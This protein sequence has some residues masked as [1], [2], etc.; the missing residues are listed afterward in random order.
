[1]P[2]LQ[3]HLQLL[4]AMLAGWV[5]EQQL[6]VI[7]YLKEEN[8]VLRG[9]LGPKRP[10]F[11]D[12]QRRRLAVKGKQLGRR[13]LAEIGCIVTPDTILRWHRQLI[14][15][16]YDGI[17]RRR[18][19]RPRVM[20]EMRQLVVQMARDNE[21][22]G[23]MRI[24]GALANLGHCVSRSTVRRILAEHGIDPAPER[25]RHTPWNKFLKA[26]WRMIA[27]ADFF[28]VEIWTRAGLTRY[29]VLFVID[30][31]S[32]RVN[33]AGITPIPDGLWMIQIARNLVDD[34]DGFLTGK[35]Y[36]VLD[37]DPLFT[38]EF[39]E[40]LAS[41]GVRPVRLPPRSPNLNAYAER[42][43][44]SIKSER[45]N[46]LIIL[47]ERHLRHVIDEYM[48]HYHTE[49]SHQGIDNRLLIPGSAHS[50]DSASSIQKRERL[51]GLLNYYCRAAA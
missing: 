18:R 15:R 11:T 22:W 10:R 28:T 34:F 7:E 31:S 49:R 30:L 35:R 41:A 2:N 32:R 48:E 46:R 43:V 20:V 6:G 50:G 25:A 3:I 16:K 29:L 5:N 4:L 27:A 36:L 23:T 38:R 26:H 1:M 24:Q 42:F 40:M 37:R 47:G 45:L 44:L 14:A 12:D 8:R 13:V 17:A 51:G 33:I 39:R 19:G 21:R 9:Q